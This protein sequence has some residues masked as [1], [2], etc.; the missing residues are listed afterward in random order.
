V[1]I[2]CKRITAVAESTEL[3][4]EKLE[5]KPE[6]IL[7]RRGTGIAERKPK[8]YME[9]AERRKERIGEVQKAIRTRVGAPRSGEG[10]MI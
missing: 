4:R 8:A 1:L 6:K 2:C 3:H 10:K 5:R 9:K 7:H